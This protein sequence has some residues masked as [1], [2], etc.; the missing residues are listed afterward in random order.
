MTEEYYKQV[1]IEAV[2]SDMGVYYRRILFIPEELAVKDKK[3]KIL[4]EADDT[5]YTV[6][7]VY[8][9]SHCTKTDMLRQKG[10]YKLLAV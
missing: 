10:L 9:H 6:V 2:I 7:H 8:E 5:T 1:Q 4:D 3:V